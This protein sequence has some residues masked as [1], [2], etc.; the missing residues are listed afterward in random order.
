ME[1]GGSDRRKSLG[2]CDHFQHTGIGIA[3][4]HIMPDHIDR[5]VLGNIR[6][7]LL[8]KVS[9][10]LFCLF[11]P[12]RTVLHIADKSVFGA[13]LLPVLFPLYDG[14][15]I[16]FADLCQDRTLYPA[17]IAYLR[18]A[19]NLGNSGLSPVCDDHHAAW[20]IIHL[21]VYIGIL[22]DKI[23]GNICC[24][25]V[26]SQNNVVFA[27][28]FIGHRVILA[29]HFHR[30]HIGRQS[31]QQGIFIRIPVKSAV[32]MIPD[33]L[34]LYICLSVRNHSQWLYNLIVH[35]D[36]QL[37]FLFYPKIRIPVILFIRRAVT[38]PQKCTDNCRN[39]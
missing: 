28:L 33:Y 14:H 23:Q 30:Y 15:L 20:V 2:L 19:A 5:I 7:L 16:A 38:F 1:P 25:S 37:P 9:G 35:R 39:H 12:E 6:K 10:N 4:G 24:A 36:R 11:I 31:I 21:I 22:L 18:I 32:D 17:L 13:D 8:L 27:L 29:P 34:I 26:R 3:V